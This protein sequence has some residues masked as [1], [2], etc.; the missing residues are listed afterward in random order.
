MVNYK[1][2]K[3]LNN[4]TLKQLKTCQNNERQ[5]TLVLDSAI[6][7][8]FGISVCDYNFRFGIDVQKLGNQQ[9]RHRVIYESIVFALGDQTL[10]ES[11]Y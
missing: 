2:I 1:T 11:V 7:F 3:P 10:V 4:Q 5:Q 9:R 6:E 8:C